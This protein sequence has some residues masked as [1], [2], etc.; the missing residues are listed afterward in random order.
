L[1][2]RVILIVQVVKYRI[3]RQVRIVKWVG[4][5]YA[6][7]VSLRYIARIRNFLSFTWLL[8]F[9]ESAT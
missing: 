1:H 2:A 7:R 3:R 8:Y 9:S 5:R 4:E 6:A